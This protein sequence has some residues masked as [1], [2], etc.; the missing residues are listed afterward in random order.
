ML[1]ISGTANTP[2]NH[3][4]TLDGLRALS[5]IV[6]L[7]GHF[8]AHKQFSAYNSILAKVTASGGL[9]VEIFFTISGFL[10]TSL[11]LNEQMSTGTINLKN[12]YL[13]R[14]FRI[15]PVLFLYLVTLVTLNYAMHIK[16]SWFTILTVLLFIAN[17]DK[18]RKSGLKYEGLFAH[19]WSLSIEEQF[20]LVIPMLIHWLKGNYIKFIFWACIAL[21]LLNSFPPFRIQYFGLFYG[22]SVGSL[23][24]CLY[25]KY[26]D[27]IS[28][29][30]AKN[31]SLKMILC[32]LLFFVNKVFITTVRINLSPIF[33]GV[34]I[35]LGITESKAVV[36]KMFNNSV[37]GFTGKLSYSLYVWQQLF[38]YYHPVK[39][40]IN[41]TDSVL[42]NLAELTIASAL[43]YYL[44]EVNMLKLRNKVLKTRK[45]KIAVRYN[46]LAAAEQAL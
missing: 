5:I 31:L 15:L 46:R 27:R 36:Y 9:G 7:I 19:F 45:N 2:K 42:I 20:Y 10:I 12:F 39:K 25:I 14:A 21:M 26:H 13:K 8:A 28:Q 43:T 18:L 11:L 6:V 35:L 30:T 23:F 32:I 22:I 29:F 34:F 17:F 24:A 33:I 38:T 4:Q 41:P 16:F 40:F 3:Y 44:L 37:A 1:D